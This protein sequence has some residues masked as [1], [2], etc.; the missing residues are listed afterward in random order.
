MGCSVILFECKAAADATGSV[1]FAVD[2]ALTN[3]IDTWLVGWTNTIAAAGSWTSMAYAFTN[4]SLRPAIGRIRIRN[5][6]SGYDDGLLLDDI[7]I[8]EPPPMNEFSWWGYNVLVTDVLPAGVED[9]ES[10]PWLA[11]LDNN[12]FAGFINNSST[13]GTGGLTHSEYSPFIQSA[14]L[15]AGIGEVRFLYRTWDTNS[16]L[17]QVVGSTN[18]LTPQ[19]EWDVLDTVYANSTSY[20]EYYSAVFHRD[21]RYVALRVDSQDSSLGRVAVDNILITEPLAA[22][23]RLSNLRTDPSVPL[24]TDEVYV[25]IEIDDLLLS[26]TNLELS[27]HYKTGTNSWGDYTSTVSYGMN[28]VEDR[29]DSFTFRSAFPI[30]QQ[31]IDTV[32]QYQVSA[33]FDGYLSSETSPK[34]YQGFVNPDHYWPVDLNRDQPLYTPYYFSLS[35]LPGQVW[36]NEFN[37]TNASSTYPAGQFIEL[38]GWGLAEIGNWR[39]ESLNPDFNTNASYVF[40]ASTQIGSLTNDFNFYVF[41]QLDVTH[42]NGDLTNALPASGG[43]QLVRSMGAIEQQ[44][45]YDVSGD[46]GAM[47]SVDPDNRFVYAGTELGWNGSSLA[48]F[49]TGESLSAFETNWVNAYA[50][51]IGTT[52]IDQMLISWSTNGLIINGY[53]GTSSIVAASCQGGVIS[54]SLDT[55]STNLIPSIWYITNLMNTTWHEAHAGFGW[56]RSNT[57]YSVWC[58]EMPPPVFYSIK[59]INTE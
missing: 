40:P 36:I 4:R 15:P 51:T 3:N 29:G 23:L 34:Y 1:A 44:V 33:E 58:D 32:V 47:M 54:F 27:L 5:M 24:Y 53:T 56:G 31:P 25:E 20:Q 2:Y 30:P 26:P 7:D 45:S 59:V 18:R 41:G 38:A 48:L 16:S 39:V 14:Y 43:L 57:T 28:L 35:C 8:I 11:R 46:S 42:R 13:N 19:A 12:E 55:Q 17:I 22:D 52:N 37:I 49:G 10:T 6:T 21:L 50:F 9:G